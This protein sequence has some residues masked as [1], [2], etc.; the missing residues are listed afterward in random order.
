MGKLVQDAQP[1][2]SKIR[3]DDERTCNALQS[4]LEDIIDQLS[5]EA[6]KFPRTL[7][8]Q[9]QSIFA[10]GYYHQ[11][12]DNKKA[13]IAGAKAKKNSPAKDTDQKQSDPEN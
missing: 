1:H 5:P 11:R 7:S 8:M 4:H 9:Q 12:A 2:L 3:K 10:L 6:D 13:A